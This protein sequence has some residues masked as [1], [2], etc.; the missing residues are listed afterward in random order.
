MIP[1][2]F[3]PRSHER[4]DKRKGFY[5]FM[6]NSISIHAPTRGATSA[7]CAASVMREISIHAPTRGA[8]LLITPLETY[9]LNF[10]PRSHERSDFVSWF[11]SILMENFN[12]R[13]HE[14][15]DC[16]ISLLCEGIFYFNPRSHER[17]D[18]KLLFLIQ[19][20]HYFNPRSHERSDKLFD[21]TVFYFLRFQSTLPREERLFTK[22]L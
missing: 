2:N 13:S 15:S 17:S 18:N 1:K 7:C 20:Y 16:L 4:S 11:V 5:I 21:I 9:A 14:R 8:T 3:N 12:P 6:D 10:N 22:F 19:H